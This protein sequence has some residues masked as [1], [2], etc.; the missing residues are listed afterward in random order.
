[1]KLICLNVECGS[2]HEPLIEFIYRYSNDIDVFCFQ[3]VFNN[4]SVIRSVLKNAR[5]NL[6]MELQNILPKFEG[7][8][9]APVENDV[10]G[11]AIFVNKNLIVNKAENIIIFPEYNPDMSDPNY[12]SMGRNLQQLEF[13]HK[14]KTYTVFNFHGMWVPK[15]KSDTEKRIEQSKKIKDIFDK[16][17]GLKILCGDLNVLPDTKSIAILSDNN[18]NLTEEYKIINTRSSFDSGHGQVVDY[19]FVSK[20]I[21]VHDFKVLRDEVSDHLPLVLD[22]S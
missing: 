2:R 11:L 9:A 1:M 17:N 3:E 4:A 6:F 22:F 21:E 8:C 14:A 18:R 7:Y 13:T 5:P 15:N 16:T 12:F 20:D 19:I 10:G